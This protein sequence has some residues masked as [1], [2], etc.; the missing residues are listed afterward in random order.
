MNNHNLSSF[1][2]VVHVFIT[3]TCTTQ[4]IFVNQI[5]DL[6]SRN[7]EQRNFDEYSNKQYQP[8]VLFKLLER[9]KLKFFLYRSLPTRTTVNN[10]DDQILSVSGKLRCSGCN[11]E[12]GE[13][14]ICVLIFY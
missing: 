3:Q 8:S 7:G 10:K 5:G 2:L 6:H 14:F 9:K 11:D 1:P 4:N 13:N 12:L